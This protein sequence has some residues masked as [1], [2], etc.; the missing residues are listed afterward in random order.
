MIP[1]SLEIAFWV[2]LLTFPL[3]Q[4]VLSLLARADLDTLIRYLTTWGVCFNLVSIIPFIFAV[5]YSIVF[6]VSTPSTWNTTTAVVIGIAS[7]LALI[8]LFQLQSY[9]ANIAI[10][11]SLKK[12]SPPRARRKSK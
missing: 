3:I 2:A 4:I 10:N 11:N 8:T 12:P 1:P 7:I 5:I 6:L 9:S